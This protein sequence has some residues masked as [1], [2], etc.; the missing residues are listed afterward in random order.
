MPTQEQGTVV[1][2]CKSALTGSAGRVAQLVVHNTVIEIAAL[3]VAT[4]ACVLPMTVVGK[5]LET[6]VSVGQQ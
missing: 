4:P 5:V 1:Q 3:V 2:A 6:G